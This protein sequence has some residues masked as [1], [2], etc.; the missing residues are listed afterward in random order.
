MSPL[1]L[2]L[3]PFLLAGS[4]FSTLAGGGLGVIAVIIGSF[5]LPVQQNIAVMAV[6]MIGIQVSKFLHFHRQARWSIVG[7]Y[8]LLGI[9]FSAAGGYAMFLLPSSFGTH[10]ASTG[11][12]IASHCSS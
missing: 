11:S 5:F 4:V 1:L 6:L 10:T 3:L 8:V 9:P 2:S 12:R 7:W